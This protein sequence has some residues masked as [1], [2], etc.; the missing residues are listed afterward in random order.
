MSLLPSCRDV[1]RLLSESR[2]TGRPLGRHVQLHLWICA[3]CRRVLEQFSVL[4][5]VVKT[6]PE[7]GPSLSKDAKKRL[8]RALDAR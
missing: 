8:R 4:G 7:S 6:P 1:S 3:V 2:D 5:S